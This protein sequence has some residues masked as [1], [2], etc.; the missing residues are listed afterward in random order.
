MTKSPYLPGLLLLLI[1]ACTTLPANNHPALS[2]TTSNKALTTD[3]QTSDSPD[4]FFTYKAII[5]SVYDGDT[6]TADIDLGFHT[7]IHGEKLRLARINA[8]ELR[9]EERPAGLQARDWL[10]EQI[11]SKTVI[12][13]TIKDKKGKYGRYI[14]EI[15][16]DGININDA[17]VSNGSAQY[18]DY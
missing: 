6:V 8:P 13:H 16:L 2:Q 9:G 17:L 1:S 14:A 3:S 11:L 15:I 18:R 4:C 5:H 7:W 12:I 10:R